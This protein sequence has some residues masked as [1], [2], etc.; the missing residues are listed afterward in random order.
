MIAAAGFH[1]EIA[2]A[3]V[4][5]PGVLLPPGFPTG[6]APRSNGR[7]AAEP[8]LRGIHHSDLSR[9]A[10]AVPHDAASSTA[11]DAPG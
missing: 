7:Y 3:A 11:R 5:R 2:G 1:G 6:C 10:A 9:Y 4:D 8:A